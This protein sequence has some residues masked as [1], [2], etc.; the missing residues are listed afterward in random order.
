MSQRIKIVCKDCG[1]PVFI[2]ANALTLD[3]ARNLS[4]PERCPDCRA[5]NRAQINSVG[6]SY[7]TPKLEVDDSKRCWGKYGLGRLE[8]DRPEPIVENYDGIPVEFP[9]LAATNPNHP[10]IPERWR[11][12]ANKF[13]K[14]APIAQELV[15]KATAPNAPSWSRQARAANRRG[16]AGESRACCRRSAAPGRRACR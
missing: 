7:W 12:T 5:K 6:Q 8:R 1:K 14:I 4:A 11:E 3:V 10:A 16:C 13:S 9:L 2:T 15:D